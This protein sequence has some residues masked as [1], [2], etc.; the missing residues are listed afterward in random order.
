MTTSETDVFQASRN[1]LLALAYQMLGELAS[2]EDIVQE[3]WL[4]WDRA[5][6]AKIAS[7]P[8]WLS[9]VVTRLSI[10]QLRSARHRRE[11]YKGTWLPEPILEKADGPVELLELAQHC[12]LA[13]LW[14]LERLTEEERAA[15]LL[16]QVFDTDYC[17][18]ATMLDK[19]EAACRQIVSRANRKIQKENLAYKQKPSDLEDIM[20][21]FALAAAAGDKQT[22]LEL[23]APDVVAVSDGGGVVRAALIPLE[24]P[25]RVATVLTHITSKAHSEVASSD[26]AMPELARVNGQPAFVL[27]KGDDRDMIFTLRLNE[28]GKVCWIYILRNPVKLSLVGSQKIRA[29]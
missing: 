8:A 13:L 28:E 20:A 29:R 25:Q 4:R 2:A 16:R 5:D 23:L 15:F 18:I 9:S 3:A 12:E 26:D 21:R 19:S 14:A 6:Q 7:P 24:G 10:D 27:L 17:D 11:T 22:V 1:Q